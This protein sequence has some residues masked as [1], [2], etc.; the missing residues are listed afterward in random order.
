MKNRSVYAALAMT[1]LPLLKSVGHALAQPNPQRKYG[2]QERQESR[3]YIAV[4]TTC[5]WRL[6]PALFWN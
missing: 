1:F 2:T 3:Q 4:T 5:W 6:R